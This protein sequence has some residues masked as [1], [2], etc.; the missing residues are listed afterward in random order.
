MINEMLKKISTGLCASLML[1]AASPLLGYDGYSSFGG[2]SS[3]GCD[4]FW[5]DAEYLYW[6]IKNSPEPVVLVAESSTAP[7]TT[8][9]PVIG[10]HSVQNNWR[11]GGK[12][13]L[14]YWFEDTRH[15]GVEA[16]YFFLPKESRSKSVSSSGAPGS[17]TLYA[18]FIDAV[19]GDVVFDNYIA[20]PG[21]FSG[22]ATRKV[23]NWMQG[24][25]LNAVAVF[26]CDCCFNLS[27]LL[28]FRYWNFDETLNFT[29][30]SPNVTPPEGV[31]Q[32]YDKF[33]VQNNFY[34]GQ[35]GGS[36]DYSFDC[37]SVNVKAKVALGAMCEELGIS[38]ATFTNDFNPEPFTGTVVEYAGGYFALPTNIGHHNKT[39]F[40]VIPEVAINFGYQ[41]TENFRVNVGYT[42]LYVSNMLWAGKQIDP[43][44]NSSQSVE[45]NGNPNSSLVG[46]AKPSANLKTSSLW[47]QGVNV[48][49]EFQ[50]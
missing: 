32:T 39:N 5:V 27:A 3:C 43:V 33:N 20:L 23:H 1:C 21:S 12:F 45:Y 13:S 7:A 8:I 15:F 38:G 36:I 47:T 40:A 41:F 49:L 22:I 18:P 34:G 29:T 10:G 48:G 9:D 14:G 37:F 28:G 26:P 6:Q 35:I 50:F 30:S 11:S 19:T 44:I 4:Q 31:F 17:L 16:N 42:F 24:A 46:V 2:S 25:E